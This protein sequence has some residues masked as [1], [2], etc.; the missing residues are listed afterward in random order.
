K[1]AF[2]TSDAYVFL[3]SAKR[4]GERWD[5]VV[6]DPPSFAPSEKAV[7]RALAAYRKLHQACVEVLADGGVFCASSCS[8]HV[9]AA[10]FLGTLDDAALMRD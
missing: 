1:H 9:G 4:R 5:L 8:S 2:V 6:S 3:D 10:R 7:P